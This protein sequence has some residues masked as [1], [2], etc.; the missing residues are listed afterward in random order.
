MP[1]WLVH[2]LQESSN[3]RWMAGPLRPCTFGSSCAPIVLASAPALLRVRREPEYQLVY[4][5]GLMASTEE[6]EDSKIIHAVH[7]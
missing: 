3:S 4:V 7:F 1:P 6:R 2:Q 5:D